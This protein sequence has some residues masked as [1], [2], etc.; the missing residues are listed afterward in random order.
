MTKLKVVD[1][2]EIYN[3]Y[4]HDFFKW[5]HLPLQILVWSCHFVIISNVKTSTHEIFARIVTT[6]TQ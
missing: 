1:L 2:D 5:N 6:K 4:V 3:F